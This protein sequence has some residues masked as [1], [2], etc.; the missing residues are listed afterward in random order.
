[1]QAI[2]VFFLLR[3]LSL[4]LRAE[5]EAQFPLSNTEAVV[6]IDQLLDLSKKSIF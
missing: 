3:D 2:R 6:Q 4:V 1:M 5:E